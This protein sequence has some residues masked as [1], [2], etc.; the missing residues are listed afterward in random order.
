M[1]Q[2]VFLNGPPGSGK[3]TIASGLVPYI[4]FRH[5]KFSAPMKRAVAGLLDMDT[6]WVE[7]FKDQPVTMLK[8]EVLRDHLIN[9]FQWLATEYGGDIL[10]RLLWK[11]A[12]L[13]ARSLIVVSD[14]G[15]TEEVEYVARRA[16]AKNC[17]LLRIHRKGHGFERDNREYLQAPLCPSHDIWNDTS[18]E[19]VTMY[20]LR[21]ITRH[22]KDVKLL[23]EPNWVPSVR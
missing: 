5:L 18:K 16:G 17:L 9:Y 20:A 22:F 19:Q 7:N 3:D 10:G 11:D 6:K 21:L 8:N 14:S 15:K 4:N 13:S 2:I 12:Q 23:R 1:P